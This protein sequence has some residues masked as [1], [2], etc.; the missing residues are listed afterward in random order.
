MDLQL[1]EAAASVSAKSDRTLTADGR[2]DQVSMQEAGL[3]IALTKS[4]RDRD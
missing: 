3:I 1:S 4:Q 2:M